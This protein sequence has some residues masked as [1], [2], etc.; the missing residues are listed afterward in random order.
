MVY[1]AENADRVLSAVEHETGD[2]PGYLR[3]VIPFEMHVDATK[4]SECHGFVD[5]EECLVESV[6]DW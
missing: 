1:D 5:I 6:A 2:A 4:E 3:E